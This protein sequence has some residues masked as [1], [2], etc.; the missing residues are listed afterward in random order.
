MHKVIALALVRWMALAL[1]L[2]PSA[3]KSEAKTGAASAD[4]APIIDPRAPY[5]TDELMTRFVESMRAD[6]NPFDFLFRAQHGGG[7]EG[8]PAGNY[9]PERLEKMNAFARGFGLAGAEEYFQIW[10][11]IMLAEMTDLA[12]SA[13][14]MG[15]DM[16]RLLEKRLQRPDLPEA[17]RR[18]LEEQLR[19]VK[20]RFAAE[21]VR[22][23]TLNSAD[24]EVV[25]RFQGAIDEAL[26]KWNQ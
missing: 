9:G 26:V 6:A 24:V 18:D 5:L 1:A 14:A 17:E 22:G 16:A 21:D 8:K 11:R 3:C 19:Q 10:T 7:E 2:A 13:R 23:S 12:E 25:R 15:D 20:E 4:A